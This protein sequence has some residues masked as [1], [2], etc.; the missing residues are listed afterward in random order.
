MFASKVAKPHAKAPAKSIGQPVLQRSMLVARPFGGGWENITAREAPRGPSWDFSKIPVFPPGRVDRSQPACPFAATPLAVLPSS[1]TPAVTPNAM[2]DGG[3]TGE[4]IA[5]GDPSRHISKRAAL[6]LGTKNEFG[7]ID[8][9]LTSD[10]FPGSFTDGGKTGSAPVHWGGGA[11]GKGNEAVGAITLAA[12]AYDGTDPAPAPAPDAGPSPAPVPARAWI[13][14]GTGT[15]SVSRSFTGA[16][17][18]ANGGGYFLTAGAST[19]VDVHER[20]H[21]AATRVIH[22]SR[23]SPLEVRIAAHVGQAKALSHGA[24]KAEAITALQTAIDWN[25][26]ITGFG[27]DETTQNSPGG[28]VDTTDQHSG[29]YIEDRGTQTVGGV[30]YAHYEAVPGEPNPAPPPPPPPAPRP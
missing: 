19:R 10:V 12:P 13:Q 21:I 23:I 14:P 6:Q 18:G 28:T 22:D 8:G 24:T 3:K 30:S 25:T 20:L 11:G 2:E 4:I 15:A 29:T 17:A 16:P 7:E 27:T 26:A 9:E 5:G 1:H